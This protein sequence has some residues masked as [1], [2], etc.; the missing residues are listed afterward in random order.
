MTKATKKTEVKKVI[1][2]SKP[3]T[4]MP[5]FE[6]FTRKGVSEMRPY[7]LGEDLT[8]VSVSKE[9]NPEKDMG[10]IA[11]NPKNHKDQ[12]YVAKAYFDENLQPEEVDASKLAEKS[13]TEPNF[14]DRLLIEKEQLEEKTVG[15]KTFIDSNP[16]YG[17][18]DQ[19]QKNLMLIQLKSMK[20][21]LDCLDRR[22]MMLRPAVEETLPTQE[23]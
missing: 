13:A 22:E 5:A 17:K 3:G 18:L 7:V 12:W 9:D 16:V 19:V 1:E 6:K 20:Q 11:R 14:Y 21:Y 2:Q 15:L 23:D 4:P 8:G 10:M